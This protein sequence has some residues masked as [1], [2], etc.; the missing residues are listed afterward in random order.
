MKFFIPIALAFA[1]RRASSLIVTTDKIQ[2]RHPIASL[3]PSEGKHD[4]KPDPRFNRANLWSYLS[5][6]SSFVTLGVARNHRRL[7]APKTSKIVDFPREA[8]ECGRSPRDSPLV[9]SLRIRRQ[10]SMRKGL[11]LC[12]RQGLRFQG[13][14]TNRWPPPTHTKGFNYRARSHLLHAPI[15]LILSRVFLTCLLSCY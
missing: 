3:N 5:Y 6:P 14:P 12:G 11:G 1:Q 7:E 13:S 4:S 10:I 2:T 8:S 9:T 15:L